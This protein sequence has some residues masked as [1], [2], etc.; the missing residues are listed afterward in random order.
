LKAQEIAHDKPNQNR[1]KDQIV[2]TKN[3]LGLEAYHHEASVDL[4]NQTSIIDT[5]D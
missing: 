1:K 3:K 4:N 2:F 5:Y